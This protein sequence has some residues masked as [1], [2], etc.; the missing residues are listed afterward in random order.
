MKARCW[1]AIAMLPFWAWVAASTVVEAETKHLIAH[2]GASGCQFYRNGS[3][4]DSERAVSHLNRKYEYL[5]KRGLVPDTEAFIE[6]AAT[7]SS[8]SGKPYRVRCGD[9]PDVP[10]AKWLREELERY[11]AARASGRR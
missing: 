7:E 10:S 6:R 3:W 4:Y 9:A 11:R 2:L 1:L 5:L 8:V